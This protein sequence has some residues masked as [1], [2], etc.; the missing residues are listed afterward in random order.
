MTKA[1]IPFIT[2]MISVFSLYASSHDYEERGFTVTYLML[3]KQ[4]IE[5]PQDQWDEDSNS[6]EKGIQQNGGGPE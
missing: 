4:H 5:L 1:I 6:S 3:E 2:I